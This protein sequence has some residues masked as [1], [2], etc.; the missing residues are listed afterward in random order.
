MQKKSLIR[1]F[2]VI[3]AIEIV[4]S[5]S[6]LA[7]ICENV[8]QTNLE[9]N[10]IASTSEL[11]DANVTGLSYRNSKFMQQ[12]RLYTTSDIVQ[13]T[14][15][16][17]QIVE[18]LVAHEKVRGGDFKEIFYCDYES[19]MAYTDKGRSFSASNYE[20]FRKMKDGNLNQ[21][22]SNPMGSSVE[23]SVYYVCKLFKFNKESV[24]FFAG[25]VSHAT[26]AKAI[27]LITVGEKGTAT[28]VSGDGL[29][30]ANPDPSIV[31][32]TNVLHDNSKDTSEY[33]ECIN[34]ALAGNTAAK[35]IEV[36]GK[37]QLTVYAPCKGTPW[38]L[39]INVPYD[40]VYEGAATLTKILVIIIVILAVILLSSSIIPL[41]RAL[42]PLRVVDKNIHE[43]ATG[44]A[45]LS[46][47]LP[48]VSNDEIG[49]VTEGFNLFME[50]LQ[51]IMTDVKSSKDNLI[52]AGD[53]LHSGIDYNAESVVE[54][55]NNIKNVESQISSQYSSVQETAGAVNE[56][57][58]NIESLERMIEK[59][60]QGVNNASSAVEQMI[61]NIS[62]VNVSVEKMAGSF[63]IL[64]K[65]TVEGNEKQKEMNERIEE[66][67]VQS[68]TLQEANKTIANIARQ[69]N[70]LAMNAAIEAAHAGEAGKGFS[71]VADEIR[72]LSETSSEQSRTIGEQLNKIKESIETVVVTSTE[73]SQTF[74]QIT[75]NI[76]ETDQLVRQISGAMSEQQEGSKQIIDSLK[77]MSNSSAEVRAASAEMAE[78]NKQILSEVQILQNS[79]QGMRSS[80]E[81]MGSSAQ[82]IRQTGNNLDNISLKIQDSIGKIGNQI[83]TF[84]V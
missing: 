18:W 24:G 77:D 73:T 65:R 7:F 48:V 5:M 57:A 80:I 74:Q 47:R 38:I 2:G 82:K 46:Q 69:T 27:D 23:D 75:N 56:I 1:R 4:I 33:K 61:G 45:D 68:E 67:K 12:L 54:I 43:I 52:E 36:Y 31:M 79:T 62:S 71:V 37:K 6:V 20:F 53:D 59:Q 51:S 76:Q 22:I 35:I 10:Y 55:L 8:V 16:C 63:D 84:Q 60:N 21:Y 81:N 14:G 42:K 9:K 58:S 83:D 39:T 29:I 41:V 28:L 32:K 66:I 72:K 3:L 15:D 26:L 44:N 30:M 78:G 49:S 19:E 64:E 50:K 11:L 13:K 70:L 25:T 40:Q 34:D 17:E